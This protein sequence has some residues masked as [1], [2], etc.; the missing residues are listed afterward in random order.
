[1]A[2]ILKGT[3]VNAA[4]GEKIKASVDTLKEQGIVPTLGIIRVGE[5]PDDLSYEKGASKRCEKYGVAVKRYLLPADCTQEQLMHTIEEVNRDSSVHGVLM[6][7]P[8]PKSLDE[9]AA[10]GALDPE[11]D[12]DGITIGS[13]AGV[14]TSRKIGFPPCTAQACMEILDYY[15]VNC[16][17]K[18]A[19]VIGRSLVVGKPAAMML[20]DRNATV[21]VCHSKT[22]DIPA[23]AR[24]ADILIVAI[25]RPKAV[26]GSCFREG[27]TVIDVGINVGEDGKLCGDANF[28]D[29]ER[30]VDAVTPVPGGV[31]SVTTTVLVQHVVEAAE[32]QTQ[33]H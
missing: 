19:V 2:K 12:I 3:E 21:T 30:I 7:R 29:A 31:G 22:V 26:G 20:L 1:M 8:L 6:F 15:G 23:I 14:F 18:K 9:E 27:Q 13:L 25:G 32:R 28:E 33:K 24:E 17:G 5:R 10:C 4:L 16:R 11:K